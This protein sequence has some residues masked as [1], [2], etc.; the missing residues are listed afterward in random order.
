MT[1]GSL[2]FIGVI[3]IVAWGKGIT[4]QFI[5]IVRG[6]LLGSLT[7]LE[8]DVELLVVF[9]QMSSKSSL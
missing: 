2:N 5:L 3:S 6:Q 4:V 7:L 1:T 8:L 9:D